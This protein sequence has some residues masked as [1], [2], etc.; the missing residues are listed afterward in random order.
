MRAF[1]PFLGLTLA[2]CSTGNAASSSDAGAHDIGTCPN[3]W[4]LP[5]NEGFYPYGS[6]PQGIACTTN[7]RCTIAV[8][9][10]PGDWPFGGAGLVNAYTCACVAG[11]WSCA[12]TSPGAGLCPDYDGGPTT[13]CGYAIGAGCD[14]GKSCVPLAGGCGRDAA[15]ELFCGCDGQ[16]ESSFACTVVAQYPSTAGDRSCFAP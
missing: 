11:A 4:H 10:C 7:D 3:A 1:L 15:P 8:H 12:I 13:I 6:P 9:D 2:A 5:T 14:A 16:A